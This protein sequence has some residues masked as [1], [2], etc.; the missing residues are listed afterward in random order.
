MNNP[1]ITPQVAPFK[2][3]CMSIGALPTSYKDS[4]DYY[5][6]LLWLIKYLEETVIPVVNNNG[7][8]VSE[9]QELYIQLKNYVTSYL[10]DETLQPLINNKLD[11]MAESGQLEQIIEQFLQ[12]TAM[13]S[14]NTVAEMQEAT[15]L[16]N[17][18]TVETLGYY[19][20][21]DGGGATYKITSTESQ[22]DYQ[23][24]LINGLYATL[25]VKD[26]MINIKQLGAYDDGTQNNNILFEKINDLIKTY[27]IFIDKGNYLITEPIEIE[28]NTNGGIINGAGKWKTSITFKENGRLIF[29]VFH[30]YNINQIH[31][32]DERISPTNPM[33]DILDGA[34]LS[35]F[36]DCIF[37]SNIGVQC[38]CA[39]MKFSDCS[40][41]KI[42]NSL[43]S[44]LLKIRGEYG[45]INNCYFEGLQ[46]ST[47]NDTG[48]ILQS[49]GPWFIN[50]CDICN[51]INGTGLQLLPLQS[52]SLNDIGIENTIF[53]RNKISID[54]N[55]SANSIS[56]VN[57]NNVTFA[58]ISGNEEK[59]INI[60]RDNGTTP[61]FSGIFGNCKISG[62]FNNT[63]TMFS[64]SSA[65]F[66]GKL[67]LNITDS[68]NLFPDYSTYF[69]IN[70]INPI[71]DSAVTITGSSTTIEKTICSN[72]PYR[73]LPRVSYSVLE[74]TGPTNIEI[75]N[76]YKGALKMV[77]TF[78]SSN[79][80]CALL[81][82]IN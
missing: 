59:C 71:Y 15:N 18:S 20:A 4:L 64:C 35:E 34:H 43:C 63:K 65:T 77:C 70:P 19:S 32:I 9:L 52:D 36:K 54:C 6:T 13:W 48:L 40:F 61:I 50:N 10:N 79:P 49:N 17:G 73:V 74:G 45:Y 24:E 56:N 39:Y 23:E 8:A 46:D 76:T 69:P 7:E 22:T 14:F 42:R 30:R 31:F 80:Y 57:L 72:S 75:Q 28:T 78:S 37:N 12:S 27:N 67:D 26:N 51:F 60:H 16:I 25:I 41:V 3:F 66:G 11:E 44:Y 38:R 1:T 58:V 68:N 82:R 33:I 81:V 55:H 5:E 21:N 62:I 29:N 2:H 53:M 47:L